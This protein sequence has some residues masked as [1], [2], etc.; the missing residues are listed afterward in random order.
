MT[1]DEERRASLQAQAFAL[2][3]FYQQMGIS[4]ET[5]ERAIEM[6][7][8]APGETDNQIPES[9]GKATPGV[10]T[11]RTRA[12][13]WTLGDVEH[14][15]YGHLCPRQGSNELTFVALSV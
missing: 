9:F 4:P 8:R 11:S 10:M 3:K 15:L 2:R 14:G 12:T 7:A 6:A 1:R 5:T 13:A